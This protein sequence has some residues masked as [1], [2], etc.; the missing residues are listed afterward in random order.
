MFTSLIEKI[1]C[2]IDVS[3]FND[4][5]AADICTEYIKS[6]LKRIYNDKDNLVVINSERRHSVK[7]M[8]LLYFNWDWCDK[9]TLINGEVEYLKI[10]YDTY[11]M[12]N[13]RCN[14][15][16]KLVYEDIKKNNKNFDG[17][18]YFVIK[19]EYRKTQE[20]LFFYWRTIKE[21]RLKI[22]ESLIKA[23][24][25]TLEIE[26]LPE[27]LI[28][29]LLGKIRSPRVERCLFDWLI[30]KKGDKT[31]VS[32]LKQNLQDFEDF[33]DEIIRHENRNLLQLSVK[34]LGISSLTWLSDFQKDGLFVFSLLDNF[35]NMNV[36]SFDKNKILHNSELII[37]ILNFLLNK[38]T[39]KAA[40]DELI[41]NE[42]KENDA[43]RL[44]I[45]SNLVENSFKKMDL[46]DKDFISEIYTHLKT[47][48]ITSS[49]DL[50]LICH[51]FS[52]LIRYEKDIINV[53]VSNEIFKTAQSMHVFK[54]FIYRKA[55]K[56]CK[57]WIEEFFRYC[58]TG[59]FSDN[60]KTP[61]QY[62]D[63]EDFISMK[64]WCLA[65]VAEIQPDFIL[66][67]DTYEQL[68]KITKTGKFPIPQ[69]IK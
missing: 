42:I 43:E 32:F 10:G 66:D 17:K 2:M 55:K 39:F 67:Y 59:I 11:K 68:K 61:E 24:K 41:S 54:F 63:K 35:R 31:M 19:E 7:S 15:I 29:Y 69:A 56:E 37:F 47:V 30:L 9:Y 22:K 64:D 18:I 12:T 33:S 4:P 57:K 36:A 60:N 34:Y 48:N 45:L 3:Y 46:K 26:S 6:Y 58:E 52:I 53:L 44:G 27:N 20:R 16:M 23:S 49:D 40:F 38:K 65:L 14:A 13:F 51:I 8:I 5:K 28:S 1:Q 50:K 25:G 21:S 62:F